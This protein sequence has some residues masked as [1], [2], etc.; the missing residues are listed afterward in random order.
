MISLP[1]AVNEIYFHIKVR[2]Y[3]DGLCLVGY[4]CMLCS[5]RGYYHIYNL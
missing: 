4:V 3:K 1:Y 5:H 2:T